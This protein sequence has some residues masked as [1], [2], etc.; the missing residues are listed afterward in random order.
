MI[1]AVFASHA[2]FEWDDAKDAVNAVKHGI[3]FEFAAFVFADPDMVIVPTIRP[4]DGEAR[5]K[6]IGIVEGKLYIAVFHRRG[7]VI[8]I[9]S[10]RRANSQETRTYGNR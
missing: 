7:D 3:D 6:A 4:E 10:A 5:E 1:K 2:T 8:R 9:I